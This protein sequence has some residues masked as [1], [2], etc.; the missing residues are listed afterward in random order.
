MTYFAITPDD[1]SAAQIKLR[2]PALQHQGIS[3]LY[4]RADAL[5]PELGRLIPLIRRHEIMPI[6]PRGLYR[7]AYGSQCAAH[8]RS[9]Q[10]FEPLDVPGLVQTASC[11]N[12]E[13]ACALLD[14]GADYVFISPVC[15]PFS[16][17]GDMRPLIET[18]ALRML[19]HRYGKRIVLLG[20]LTPAR[21][22][23]LRAQLD[24]EFSVG[25][26]SMFFTPG[27]TDGNRTSADIH[28]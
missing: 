23:E 17:P 20:G 16:K 19:T 8:T 12:P 13:Q 21:I 25:G 11:H 22:D 3:H 4:L 1:T 5:Q 10:R 9:A 24:A 28:Q 15:R 6:I 27:T 18:G 7:P 14:S 2:L 26:I